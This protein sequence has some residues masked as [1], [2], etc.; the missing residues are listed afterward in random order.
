MKKLSSSLFK[1]SRLTR[2]VEVVSSG[3]P[4]KITR[5]VKNKWLGKNVIRKLYKW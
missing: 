3:S 5:R 4:T 1:L 2:D